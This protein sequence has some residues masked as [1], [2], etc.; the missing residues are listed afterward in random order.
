MADRILPVVTRRPLSVIRARPGQPPFMQKNVPKSTPDWVATT[1]IWAEASRRDVRYAL[2]DDRRTLLWFANQRAVELHPT[3]AKVGSWSPTDLVLDL[4]PPEGA[5]FDVVI[6]TAH[7]VREA[8]AQVGPRRRPQDEWRE[9]SSPVRSGHRGHDGRGCGGRHPRHRR[10]RREAR[11]RAATTAFV[12]ADREGKVF[13]DSTRAGGATVV[14]AYSPRIRPGV[15]CPSRWRGMSSTGLA[16]DHTIANV[17]EQL[18]GRDPWSDLMPP[19]QPLPPA[20]TAEGPR[21]PGRARP[22]DARRKRR[23]RGRQ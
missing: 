23:A 2:C 18:A 14:A 7:L 10:T 21:H 15:R 11:P 13:V 3:L 8:L 17:V 1:T 6:R 20:L 22:G 4:D 9:G 12:K 16:G 5:A 19:P